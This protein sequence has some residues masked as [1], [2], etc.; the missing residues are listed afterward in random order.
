M[1]R[2]ET[3]NSEIFGFLE[4]E[5]VKL[6]KKVE[7]VFVYV[8]EACVAEARSRGS[9]T[10]RTGN[11]RSS[12]GYLVLNAGRIVNEN[13][14]Q[15]EGG[16]A[17]RAFALETARDYPRDI[18][19]ILVAGMPYAAAVASR[20]YDVLDSGELLAEAMIPQMLGQLKI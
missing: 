12:V 7:R 3:P 9:Y 18:V 6:I 14:K 5:I 10:D 16:E 8:G 17:A 20:G 13:F 19:L 4:N 15:G 11:L 2:Q 1:I